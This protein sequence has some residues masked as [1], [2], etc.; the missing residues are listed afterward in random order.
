MRKLTKAQQNAL[1]SVWLRHDTPRPPYL[2]FRRAAH[3]VFDDCLMV[4][5]S[6]MWL[7]IETDGYTHS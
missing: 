6:G 2:A 4:G 5:Y 3:L 7:G 1:Y